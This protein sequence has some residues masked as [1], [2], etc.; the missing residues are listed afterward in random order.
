MAAPADVCLMSQTSDY[1]LCNDPRHIRHV[2]I[3]VLLG[4]NLNEVPNDI[5]GGMLCSTSEDCDPGAS[6]NT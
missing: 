2:L 4:V 6:H 3:V 5:G 1:I